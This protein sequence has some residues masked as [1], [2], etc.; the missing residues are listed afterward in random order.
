MRQGLSLEEFEH[1]QNLGGQDLVDAVARAQGWSPCRRPKSYHQIPFEQKGKYWWIGCTCIPREKYD[2]LSIGYGFG[3]QA[4]AL[5]TEFGL[6]IQP[7][8]DG[9]LVWSPQYGTSM[10]ARAKS[11]AEA[12]CRAVVINFRENPKPDL[13]GNLPC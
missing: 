3:H 5:V 8:E 7:T 2:P 10:G 11:L 12:I 4:M 1:I 6:A 13:S 9:W